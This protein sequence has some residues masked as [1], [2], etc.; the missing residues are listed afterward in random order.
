MDTQIR[1]IDRPH[2]VQRKVPPAGY[3]MVAKPLNSW[4]NCFTYVERIDAGW[5]DELLI[6]HGYLVRI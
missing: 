4:S 5:T 6:K 2:G 1:R 3:R